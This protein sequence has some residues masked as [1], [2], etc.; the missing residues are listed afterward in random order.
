MAGCRARVFQFHSPEAIG[1]NTHD[2]MITNRLNQP[3]LD[4]FGL[5]PV[6]AESK[7]SARMSGL[8]VVQATDAKEVGVGNPAEETFCHPNHKQPVLNPAFCQSVHAQCGQDW[9]VD[10]CATQ[11]NFPTPALIW[12]I[13]TRRS[14]PMRITTSCSARLPAK[15]ARRNSVP[16]PFLLFF[17]ARLD[18]LCLN[19]RAKMVGNF[20]T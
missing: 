9:R 8:Q 11:R 4:R 15:P 2:K 18:N 14:I 1:V 17:I 5:S 3:T 16:S 6:E 7:P 13:W 10:G 19:A 12:F 20:M